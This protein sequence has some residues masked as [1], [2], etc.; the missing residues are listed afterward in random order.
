MYFVPAQ[1]LIFGLIFTMGLLSVPAYAADPSY[2]GENIRRSSNNDIESS[3][4]AAQIQQGAMQAFSGITL[5]SV[6]STSF[7]SFRFEAEIGYQR[8]DADKLILDSG[9]FMFR[10]N[11]SVTSYMVNGYYNFFPG[12]GSPYVTAGFGLAQVSIHNKVNPTN[13]ISETYSGA[14]YQVGIGFDVIAAKN[15]FFDVRYRYF[16]TYPVS[17]NNHNGSF[18]APGNSVVFGLVVGL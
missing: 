9:L 10:G 2:I 3:N 12:T 11:Y 17:L 7:K 13:T 8:N 16:G 18:K 4:Q 14:G 15:I 1:R 6:F 5:M